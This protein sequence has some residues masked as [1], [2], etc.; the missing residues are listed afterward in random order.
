[1]EYGTSLV[2]PDK[3]REVLERKRIGAD[4]GSEHLLNMQAKLQDKKQR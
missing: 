2:M 3:E 1:M 4:I